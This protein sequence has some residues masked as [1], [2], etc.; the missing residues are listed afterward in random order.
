MVT[1]FV[2]MV[3]GEVQTQMSRSNPWSGTLVQVAALLG[4]AASI[5]ETQ[6]LRSWRVNAMNMQ[7]VIELKINPG[8]DLSLSARGS[9]G[10]I[11]VTHEL[12]IRR[13]C[14]GATKNAG[15]P[16]SSSVQP[17]SYS[18]QTFPPEK[19]A[20][21]EQTVQVL[22]GISLLIFGPIASAVGIIYLILLT[23]LR[24]LLQGYKHLGGRRRENDSLA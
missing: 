13:N 1:D 19:I 9:P 16:L 10:M 11:K 23:I 12:V 15:Q 2:R 21:L 7:P 18:P 24:K 6:D 20:M 4:C 3:F 17:G 22:F 5:K 8:A 14:F